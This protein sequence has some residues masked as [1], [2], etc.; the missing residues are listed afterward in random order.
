MEK[1][2]FKHSPLVFWATT[3]DKLSRKQSP[4]TGKQKGD[5]KRLRE[6]SG[7]FSKGWVSVIYCWITTLTKC[8]HSFYYLLWFLW[9]GNLGKAQLNNSGSELP[10]QLLL[11]MG[12]EH[13]GTGWPWLHVVSG[14][15]VV[16]ASSH[17]V[18]LGQAASM[19]LQ[20][21]KHECSGQPVYTSSQDPVQEVMQLHSTV[22]SWLQESHMS[23]QIQVDQN[24][25]L[26][27]D[28]G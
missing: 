25:S 1:S 15:R 10:I 19:A 23:T 8:R 6:D 5:M 7:I 22:F 28:G 18:S 2:G 20:S 9:F 26:S 21:S 11:V 3:P 13:L 17:H 27:L 16:W 12:L 14:P 24:Q 4:G